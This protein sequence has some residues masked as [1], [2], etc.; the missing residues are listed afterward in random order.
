[1]KGQKYF[2]AAIFILLLIFA[3]TGCS[4]APNQAPGNEQQTNTAE[5]PAASQGDSAANYQVTILG[6]S[7]GGMWS[8]ITEGVA[9]SIRRGLPGGSR[10]TTE[11]GKDGPNQ[12]MVNTGE[13]ELAVGYEATALAAINAREPYRDKHDNLMGVAVLSPIM[14]FQFFID[15]KSGITSFNELADKKYPLKLSAN[16]NGSMMEIVTRKVLE[17]HGASYDNIKK[18]GGKVEFLPANEALATWDTGLLEAAGEVA[19]Y[20]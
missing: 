7:A 3:V 1:M 9:E 6:G 20:P 19:Q 5:E 2:L 11:P 12:T 18:W 10:I 15:N 8:V 16:K 17:A 4:S 14:P 13:V